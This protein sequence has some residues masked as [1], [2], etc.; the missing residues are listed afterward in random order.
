MMLTQLADVARKAGLKVVEQPG[1]KSA[2][3]PG[4]ML[5]V[6]TI[7]CHHTANGGA[8]GNAPSLGTVVHGRPGL[9]GPLAHYLLAVDGTVH[10]VAAGKCN[11]AGVSLKTDYQNSYAVGIEA[12]AK[13]V[14]GTKTDWPPAQMDA[15]HQ[16]CRALIAEF[17]LS[18]SDVRGHKETC[19]P[20]GRKTD[21]DFDMVKFRADV[22]KVNLK[23]AAKEPDV[24]WDDKI[25][26]TPTDAKIWG[27]DY[28]AGDEVTLGL[29]LRYP[30][31]VRKLEQELNA[32]IK[33]STAREAATLA[34][35]TA[36]TKGTGDI[37]P[38]EIQAVAQAA[39]EAALAK[40]GSALD[41][42]A[43]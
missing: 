42:T 14:P 26:L 28:K 40:L 37:T 41:P 15:Y 13:G 9:P 20:K 16:L 10:V 6:R 27:G 29:M 31:S 36:A 8:S 12:E 3:R 33:A 43:G 18:V 22:L 1:W 34:A 17:H 25:K 32:F 4:G 35:L 19:S 7:T 21:P 23:T 5:G 38:V 2:G 24:N 30:T 39:A 11:H